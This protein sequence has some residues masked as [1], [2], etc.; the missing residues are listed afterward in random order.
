M[1]IDIIGVSNLINKPVP[2]EYRIK[3]NSKTLDTQS[4]LNALLRSSK[5]EQ[6]SVS[7]LGHDLNIKSTPNVSPST[8]IDD[9]AYQWM[10]NE[11][12]TNM[13]VYVD[14]KRNIAYYKTSYS[15]E[16]AIDRNV[17]FSDFCKEIKK[18]TDKCIYFPNDGILDSTTCLKYYNI[19]LNIW[20]EWKNG[21]VC[22]LTA[23]IGSICENSEIDNKTQV[24]I[25]LTK[26]LKYGSESGMVIC[27]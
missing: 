20:E 17:C 9:K 4:L 6:G 22:R 10:K 2:T 15:K 24:Y 19:L 27:R 11:Q 3:P 16:S 25:K 18:F 7:N 13:L 12:D 5:H 23:D 14:W 1:S 26:I 21:N 8:N